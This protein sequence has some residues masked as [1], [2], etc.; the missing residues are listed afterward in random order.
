MPHRRAPV[1]P[2]GPAARA[3]RARAE[4]AGLTAL[5]MAV[6]ALLAACTSAVPDGGPR[7]LS[8]DVVVATGSTRGVYHAWAGALGEELTAAYPQVKVAVLATTGSVQNLG[9]IATGSATLALA[10]SDAVVQAMRGEPPFRRPVPVVALARI[11]DDYVHLVVRAGSPVRR[12]ADLAGRTVA[13]GSPG[14]GTALIAGRVLQAARV[15]VV[16]ARSLGLVEGTQAL[17]AGSV[18]AL[19]WSGGLPTAA[20]TELAARVPVRLVALGEVAATLRARWGAVYRPATVPQGT[21]GAARP[22]PSIAAANLLV[23]RADASP[24]LV[25]AVLAVTFARRA[26]MA[27]TVPAGN[28]LDPRAAIATEPVALHPGARRYYRDTKP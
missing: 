3:R 8:A 18:D 24:T 10:S 1:T 15:R 6:A 11:Y 5:I 16:D 4:A 2:C 9:M 19:F 22:V 23:C 14:S 27:A 28:T 26:A 25:R 12:V 13:I 20:M 17:A 7:R 21:Y